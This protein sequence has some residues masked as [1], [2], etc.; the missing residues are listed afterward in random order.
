[1]NAFT[2]GQKVTVCE[3][4]FEPADDHHPG[5]YLCSKGDLLVVRKVRDSGKWP[6]HV[7]HEHIT[8]RSF[9]V[10]PDEIEATQ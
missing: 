5:G 7:S 10:S 6:I 1:V 3:A 9:C 8:D 4:I 2:V